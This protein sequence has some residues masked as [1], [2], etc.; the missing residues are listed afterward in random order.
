MDERT[1]SPLRHLALLLLDV[2]GVLTEGALIYTGEQTESKVFNV[3]DGLGIKMLQ[4]CGVRIGIVT[5]RASAALLRRCRELGVDLVF[6][7]ISDK[8]AVLEEILEKAGCTAEETGFMGDDLPDLA[9]F[10]KVG[11]A[12]AV[13]DAHE[14]VHNRADI[15]TAHAGGRGAVR[16]ICEMII[17][18]KGLWQDQ[19]RRWES[20]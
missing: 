5:G 14:N 12:V 9:L 1:Q 3:K 19:L 2:D 8:G 10:G 18:S 13:A 7:G 17:K 11:V 6:D 20:P 16:E 4:D 15:I